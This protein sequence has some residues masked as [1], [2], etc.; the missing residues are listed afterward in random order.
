[1]KENSVSNV[2]DTSA[3]LTLI[4]DEGGAEV[5]QSLLEKA[6]AGSVKIF[7]SFMSFMDVFCI[8]LPKRDIEEAAMFLVFCPIIRCCI[9]FSLRP[10][11]FQY[12]LVL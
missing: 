12:S 3:W 5:V 10:C 9:H 1:M 7:T 6:D 8:T 4:E 2:L 11:S